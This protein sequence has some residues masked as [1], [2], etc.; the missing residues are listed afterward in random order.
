VTEIIKIQNST[1]V[2]IFFAHKSPF[3]CFSFGPWRLRAKK[4]PILAF[5]GFCAVNFSR[6][7]RKR[8]NFS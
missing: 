4:N 3:A 5:F 7:N 8:Q 1:S 6:Q 2:K